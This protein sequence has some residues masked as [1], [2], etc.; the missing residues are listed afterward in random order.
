MA[1]ARST[2]TH[3]NDLGVETKKNTGKLNQQHM[4]CL[5]VLAYVSC[6]GSV[7]A[8][9]SCDRVEGSRGLQEETGA[10]FQEGLEA[11]S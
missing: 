9:G 3:T 11:K 4:I 1:A 7:S 2:Q 5:P 10:K 6:C 8:R